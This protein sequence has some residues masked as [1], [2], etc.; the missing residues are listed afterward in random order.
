MSKFKNYFRTNAQKASIQVANAVTGALNLQRGMFNQTLGLFF[1]GLRDIYKSL[2]YDRTLTKDRYI[3]YY[4]R[5]AIAKAVVKAY[6]DACWSI[7][8][9][10]I[11]NED[12]EITQ[13]EKDIHS[14]IKDKQM[15]KYMKRA[16]R[17]SGVLT[18]SVLMIGFKDSLTVDQPAIGGDVAFFQAFRESEAQIHSYENNINNERFGKPL[19]YNIRIT[20][21]NS[22]TTIKVHWTRIIH[23][24]EECDSGDIH[25]APRMEACWNNLYN[26]EKISGASAEG[27]WR[28]GTGGTVAEYDKEATISEDDAPKFKASMS[29][30]VDG[31]EKSL[32]IKG[33]VVK[34]L[35]IDMNDPSSH[36]M[37][38]VQ[39]IS[40]V[41]K[42]PQRIL[43]GTEQGGLASTQDTNRW[44]DS[45]ASR[46]VDFCNPD[47][48]YATIDRL[49]DLGS[50]ATPKDGEYSVAWHDLKA[51][52]DKTIA[53]TAKF[54]TEALV[55]YGDSSGTQ[56]IMPPETYYKQIMKM[57]DEQIEAIEIQEE[58]SLDLKEKDLF[59][60]DE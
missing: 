16:D 47:I 30:W 22:S 17:I 4:N 7:S 49:I 14:L 29:K 5:H 9:E 39:Q 58:E 33:G 24:A 23:I 28:N 10:I 31:F 48:I 55:K 8:P 1:G 40:A 42:I 21:D 45:V 12:T 27:Y 41:T 34:A 25:G 20:R 26:I 11:E 15:F 35:N 2:G 32:V 43:V 53:E 56:A 50:V 36:F 19:I 52:D 54:Q 51:K 37:V 6:P 57:T 60:E 13:F 44:L 59:P 46:Q 3:N 18:Y 38:E